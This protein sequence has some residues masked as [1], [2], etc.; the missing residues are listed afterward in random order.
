[1]SLM[2]LLKITTH[3]TVIPVI[4]KKDSPLKSD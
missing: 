3:T 1:M 2:L 4:P